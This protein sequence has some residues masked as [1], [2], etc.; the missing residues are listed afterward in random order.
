VAG[1]TVSNAGG[2]GRPL[3]LQL[4]PDPIFAFVHEPASVSAGPGV[5]GAVLCPPFGW[6]DICSYRARRAWA[7]A[8]ACAGHPAVRIDLPGT[9]DSVGSPRDPDRLE[10][11]T[12]AVSGTARWLRTEFGC[13]RV[14]AIG[15]GLGGI[16]ACRA[17]A[18]GAGIDD[19]VLWAVPARGRAF[20]RE[21]RALAALEQEVSRQAD[22]HA[23]PEPRSDGELEVAGQVMTTE[24]V[25]S[26]E[27]I[28]LTACEFD[29][30]AS[31]RVLL[32]DRD[33]MPHDRRLREHLE[34]SGVAVTVAP[35]DGYGEMMEDPRLAAAPQAVIARSISWLAAA[36]EESATSMAPGTGPP[37][38][39]AEVLEFEYEGTTIR[40]TPVIIERPTGRLFGILTE[41]ADRAPSGPTALLMNVGAIRRIGPN[42]MWVELARRWSARGT[43]SLR[44]D[45]DGIGDADGE[46]RQY[47]TSFEF[48][49]PRFIEHAIASLDE[50]E[51]RDVADRFI[52]A[53]LCSSAYWAFHCALAD[54]RVAAAMTVNLHTFFWSPAVAAE[55]MAARSRRGRTRRQMARATF[56]LAGARGARWWLE[57]RIR[58]AF[59]GAHR[60]PDGVDAALDALR[61]RPADL[62]L[63]FSRGEMLHEELVDDG[64]IENLGRW[65]NVHVDF[66]P[67]NDHVVREIRLQRCVHRVFD[68]AL[69]RVLGSGEPGPVI[70][71][72]AAPPI[73]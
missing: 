29:H 50:L 41:P 53:G 32:L 28:D 70:A 65:P 36:P 62:L 7:D 33:S 40:E 67:G 55:R 9:G 1:V 44:I 10:T 47:L 26:L 57:L 14:V 39:T 68:D 54:E 51:T 64:R 2:G 25:G 19:L 69:E 38:K 35:G 45:F 59:S 11:W 5:T 31:R 23:E 61:D 72:D 12:D 63:L 73:R 15:I 60:G 42:R 37:V 49:E 58:A 34:Q 46:E 22:L 21:L 56:T 24:T 43:P 16:L 48:Y 6:Q 71:Q 20:I 3:Y 17:V 8:L 66:I 18:N 13:T 52:V 30:G 4:E 27:R